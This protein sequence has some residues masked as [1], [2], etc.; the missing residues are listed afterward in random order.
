MPQRI[1]LPNPIDYIYRD[2]SILPENHRLDTEEEADI[3]EGQVQV[4][5]LNYFIFEK[6]GK[7]AF[8]YYGVSDEWWKD[9]VGFGLTI[10]LTGDFK[11]HAWAGAWDDDYLGKNWEVIILGDLTGISKEKSPHWRAGTEHILWL[12]SNLG[13]S[14]ALLEPVPYYH[15]ASWARVIESWTNVKHPRRRQNP[16]FTPLMRTDPRPKWW[17]AAGDV[18]WHDGNRTWQSPKAAKTLPRLAESIVVNSD[19]GLKSRPSSS[20]PPVASDFFHRR[21]KVEKKRSMALETLDTS[22]NERGPTKSASRKRR[23]ASG[24]SNAG[25]AQKARKE[26]PIYISSDSDKGSSPRSTSFKHRVSSSPPPSGM[27]SSPIDVD[28]DEFS[29]LCD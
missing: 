28:A 21:V 11:Y 9:V 15:P 19:S 20:K 3:E 29:A 17:D 25:R 2:N 10:A 5:A 13:Y 16:G 23:A 18:Q 12:E 4:R 22:H 26:D 27:P 6:N 1:K 24:S 7:M 14:Y 8:P